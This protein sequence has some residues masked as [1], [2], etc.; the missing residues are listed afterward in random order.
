MAHLC[1]FLDIGKRKKRFQAWL[2]GYFGLVGVIVLKI[3]EMIGV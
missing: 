2:L 3:N 1:G